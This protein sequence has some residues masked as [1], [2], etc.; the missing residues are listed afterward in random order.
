M[1]PSGDILRSGKG[2]IGVQQ[3][4]AS[5][6][7]VAFFLNEL[8]KVSFPA[9]HEKYKPA[10]AAGRWVE[11]DPG[12]WLGRAIVYKLQVDIHVDGLDDGPAAIFNVGSFTGG[13]LNIPDLGLV[14]EYG[15]L[16]FNHLVL[17]S[18]L[19]DTAPGM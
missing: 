3:Y 7:P 8:F 1:T 19:T 16:L 4:F 13:K 6:A 10:F 14:L 11:S 12:P 17:T 9:Y 15:L 2:A 5:S 18:T